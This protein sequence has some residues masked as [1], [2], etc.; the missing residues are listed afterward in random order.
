MTRL[1]AAVAIGAV[2]LAA[3]AGAAS[4]RVLELAPWSP[5]GKDIVFSRH[6]VGTSSTNELVVMNA[7]GT[8]SVSSTSR[9]TAAAAVPSSGRRIACSSSTTTTR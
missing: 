8:G 6:V 1:V 7:D 4:Y 2:V 5:D 3:H 9:A